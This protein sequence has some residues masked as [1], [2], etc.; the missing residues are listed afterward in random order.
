MT[1]AYL[2]RALHAVS[3]ALEAAA[4]IERDG[5]LKPAQISELVSRLFQVR[6]QIVVL[7][8]ELRAEWRRRFGA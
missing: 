5:L 8:G 4:A 6:D 1:I 2:K 3:M 7:M